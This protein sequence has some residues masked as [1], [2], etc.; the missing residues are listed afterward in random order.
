MENVR[1]TQNILFAQNTKFYRNIIKF[2]Y[3]SY[4]KHTCVQNMYK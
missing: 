1:Y 2:V 3:L 4:V